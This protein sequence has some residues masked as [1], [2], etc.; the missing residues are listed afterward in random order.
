MAVL[1]YVVQPVIIVGENDIILLQ[2]SLPGTQLQ[3]IIKRSRR[4]RDMLM[5]LMIT[6]FQTI[7]TCTP[8]FPKLQKKYRIHLLFSD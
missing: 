4:C 2:T 3:G 7:A 5:K 8:P 1:L 6:I